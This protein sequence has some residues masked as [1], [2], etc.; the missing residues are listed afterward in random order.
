[1]LGKHY[2]PSRE[3]NNDY[4]VIGVN[5]SH[6][7]SVSVVKNGKLVFYREE[8]RFDHDKHS[9]SFINGFAEAYR[10]YLPRVIAF[11]ATYHFQKGFLNDKKANELGRNLVYAV[12]ERLKQDPITFSFNHHQAHAAH[13][14]Y[15]SGFEEAGVLVIDG[16]GSCFVN[17][18]GMPIKETESIYTFSKFGDICEYKCG[19]RL[20]HEFSSNSKLK[21]ADYMD[22]D[23]N[24]VESIKEIFGDEHLSPVDDSHY[25]ME[26]LSWGKMFNIGGKICCQTGSDGAGKLMG[27]AAYG[28]DNQKY[29]KA[30]KGLRPDTTFLDKV[31]Y[32]HSKVNKFNKDITKEDV[33]YRIQEDCFEPLCEYVQKTIDLSGSDNICLVGGFFYNVVNNYK[34]LKRFPNINFYVEPMAGDA[35]CSIGT[36]YLGYRKIAPDSPITPTKTLY[37]G[38]EADY[39]RDYNPEVAEEHHNVTPEDVAKLI[40]DRNVV[41]LYQGRAEAGPR[42]L[43]NRSMLYD[44]RDPNGRDEVNKIKHREFYRPFAGSVMEEHCH[45]WFDFAGMKNSP[46]MMY[47]VDCWEDKRDQVP[48]LQHIDGTC[49]I[50]TVNEE[51]NKH[52]YRLIKAFYELT[53]IPM[54]LN[55]S[56]NLAGDTIVDNMQDAWNTCMG[57]PIK[58]LYCPERA[59]LIEFKKFNVRKFEGKAKRD[60]D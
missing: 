57:A 37:L 42:A 15:N 30:W 59:M 27:L 53:G 5:V 39:L 16:G 1:M 21:F 3:E 12:H 58:Y 10:R 9:I 7:A 40:A 47:A 44:P 50:Q 28:T 43:G 45:D 6:D 32:G 54:V 23:A 31:Y 4:T 17:K 18:E 55:T 36:A 41:A 25:N 2:L 8:E 56:F 13:A 14:Y 34:L 35:G 46:H 60:A 24:S 20:E 29:G 11:S 49:R 51:Q 22:F 52:Y 38:K 19:Y 48:A 33:A 26:S